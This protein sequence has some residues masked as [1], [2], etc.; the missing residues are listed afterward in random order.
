[1]RVCKKSSARHGNLVSGQCP[2]K[3]LKGMQCHDVH[4]ALINVM[5]CADGV[6]WRERCCAKCFMSILC[7]RVHTPLLSGILTEMPGSLQCCAIH[8]GLAEQDFA[9]VLAMRYSE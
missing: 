8:A 5:D 7:E 2:R 9:A 1:M 6:S 4:L 3:K